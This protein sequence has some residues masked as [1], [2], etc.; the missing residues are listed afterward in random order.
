MVEVR[1]NVTISRLA[2]NGIPIEFTRRSYNGLAVGPTIRVRP[3]DTLR[4]VLDN[5]LGDAAPSF[6]GRFFWGRQTPQ[7][8][9]GDWDHDHDVY[10]HPNYTNLHLH[11]MHVS[12][13]GVADNVT[14]RCAPQQLLQYEY[15]I[16]PDHA[17][18][19]FWYHPHF[20][21]ASALQVASGMVGA[22]IVEDDAARLQRSANPLWRALAAMEERVIV[23][24]EVSHSNI[25]FGE[26]SAKNVLCFFCI[27]DF[28]WPSG[29]RLRL[30]KRYADPA[31]AK[32]GRPSAPPSTRNDFGQLMQPFDCAFLLLNGAFAPELALVAGAYQRWRVVQSAHQ[33]MLR[34]DT[35]ALARA[36][37][38][39][40]L[41]ALDGAYLDSPRSLGGAGAEPFVL[42]AGARADLAVRCAS[43]GRFNL[44]SL[45]GGLHRRGNTVETY[46]PVVYPRPAIATL[47]VSPAA[48]RAPVPPPLPTTEPLPPRPAAMA[49]LRGARPDRR[50]V[51]TYNLTGAGHAGGLGQF[52]NGGM[53]SINDLSFTGRPESCM[54]LGTVQEWTV[55]NAPNP[56]DRWMHSFHIHVNNFQVIAEQA[57]EQGQRVVEHTLG[58]WRDT[59][60][61]PVGGQVV[62][63]MNVTDFTGVFP[64]HCHVTAHQDLG[65]MQFVRV[66][67]RGECAEL[68]FSD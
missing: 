21:Q 68:G 39:L 48:P 25:G 47:V 28:A 33:S 4:I 49:D 67:R 64:F 8:R 43:P 52:K 40:W 38:E 57:G 35:P 18:G 22:L 46:E 62:L 61:V 26:R 50:F 51:V 17:T 31:F 6:W 11:G 45:G 58:D 13:S 20:D 14:R 63:R 15:A 65:M 44:S 56:L 55:I 66:A 32:C 53:F 24:H 7:N 23:L 34:L 16:P 3:G 29:D 5:Q 1:L 37:C 54:E 19:T 2:G 9:T 60:V 59:V 10:S 27:D 30:A 41:L 42:P 12:P 36:G